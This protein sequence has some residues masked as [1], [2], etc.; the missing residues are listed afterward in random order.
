MEG[1][2]ERNASR[3]QGF[4]LLPAYVQGLRLAEKDNLDNLPFVQHWPFRH[5]YVSPPIQANEF[6]PSSEERNRMCPP[7]L[8]HCPLAL[9][10]L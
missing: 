6:M 1:K 2:Q 9:M 7:T 3:T 5:L 8:Y 10:L 4:Q